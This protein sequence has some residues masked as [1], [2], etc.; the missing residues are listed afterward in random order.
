MARSIRQH[1]AFDA[2]AA[3][4]SGTLLA[5]GD[6]NYEEAR[7]VHNSMIDKQPALI[8]QCATPADVTAAIA[9]GCDAR[10]EI[11]VRAGGHSV[12]GMSLSDGGTVI[13]VRPMKEIEIDPAARTA[14]VG[15]GVTWVSSTGPR[16][17]TASP[18]PA[19]ESRRQE[20][21]GS[22]SAVDRDGSSASTAS[23]AT[24]SE[25]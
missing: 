3:R 10:L 7:T 14:R 8:A 24:T 15:A 6:A 23:R 22:R 4:F 18:P 13:D 16:R 11:A 2:L 19:G 12:A 9:F 1:T 17:S 20:S 5:P 25:P 21:P